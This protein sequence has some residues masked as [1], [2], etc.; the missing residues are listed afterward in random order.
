MPTM[1]TAMSR[2]AVVPRHKTGR[3]SFARICFAISHML[4]VWNAAAWGA[5]EGHAAPAAPTPAPATAVAAAGGTGA[6]VQPEGTGKGGVRLMG[7]GPSVIP[8]RLRAAAAAA[9]VSAAAERAAVTA[10]AAAT[11]AAEQL[12]LL[13]AAASLLMA[14]LL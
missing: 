1:G 14:G 6:G 11:A 3:P 2:E 8:H 5:H 7:S 4:L 10:A 12:P 13:E 9:A